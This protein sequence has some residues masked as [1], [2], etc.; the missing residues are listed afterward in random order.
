M[1]PY[2][3]PFFVTQGGSTAL[4]KAICFG[5]EY[6]STSY[7][8]CDVR[9]ECLRYSVEAEER[10]GLWGG[11]SQRERKELDAVI[12]GKHTLEP[13]DDDLLAISN[14]EDPDLSP[15]PLLSASDPIG[16]AIPD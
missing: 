4:A 7:P 1:D 3:S 14:E 2:E 8:G 16:D 9:L 11:R 10:F 6:L 15:G 12:A 13:T 5:G